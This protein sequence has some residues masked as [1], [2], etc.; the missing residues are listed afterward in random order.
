MIS[1]AAEVQ[2]RLW[3][4]NPRAWADLAESHNRPLF[5]A[6][7]D[8]AAVGPGTA[9]LDVGCGTGLT[10]VLASE[11]GAV[12]SGVDISPGLLA[13]ARDRLPPADLREADMESLPFGD[14]AFDAVT[15]VNAFQFAGDPRRALGEAARVTRPGG[16]V[17]ASLFA[18]PERSEGTVAHE[19]MTALIPPERADDHAP[20]A[21]SAPGNLEASLVSAGLTLDGDGEVVCHWRY[22]DMDEAIRALLCSAGGA[23]A[24]EAAGQ[25]AVRGA[26]NKTLAQFRVSGTGTVTL[27]N[28]FRWVAASKR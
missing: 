4:T 28:I 19:A 14:A 20:Y 17:V 24:A 16:R 7:L 10:L 23:R 12:P 9:V 13:I 3:G 26:L 25:Q 21:L 8:A 1:A 18:A 11:R 5:E 22:A 15:G 2:R 27:R 6:V